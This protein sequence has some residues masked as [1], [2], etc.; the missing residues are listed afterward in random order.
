MEVRAA[1]NSQLLVLGG[2]EHEGLGVAA[3]VQSERGPIAGT[4]E[5]HRDLLPAGATHAPV[6]G[7]EVVAHV[8]PQEVVVK[9]VRVVAARL[10]EQVVRGLRGMPVG[11]EAH[12]EDAA[13]VDLVA[14][15]VGPSFPRENRFQRRGLQIR[16]APL[17]GR[18]V[19]D[20]ERADVA[21]APRP[22]RDP[23]DRVVKIQRFL[24]RAG[25]RLAGRFARPAGVHAHERITARAPPERIRRLPVHVGIGLFLQVSR[26]NP[27]L[28]FLVDADV[29]DGGKALGAAVRAEHVGV[30]Y[31]A[32]PRRDLHVLLD[33]QLVVAALGNVHF[34]F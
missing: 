16:Q 17:R 19:R 25:L 15:L 23:L 33:D 5:R 24:I 14:V 6:F 34:R 7:I 29:H 26:R 21:G 13:V 22:L 8:L 11:H 30:E 32:V 9:S 12:R 2:G 31:R 4:V 20:A 28:V 3:Q 18:V 10:A 1:V 27:Q